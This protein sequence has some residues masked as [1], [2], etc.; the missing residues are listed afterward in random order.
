MRANLKKIWRKKFTNLRIVIKL[1]RK[2]QFTNLCLSEEQVPQLMC[3][4]RR[5]YNRVNNI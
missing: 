4:Y 3:I 1:I 2:K 5:I